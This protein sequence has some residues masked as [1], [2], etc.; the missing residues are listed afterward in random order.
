MTSW[1]RRCAFSYFGWFGFAAKYVA[2]LGVGAEYVVG[3][4]AN[5]VNL[6]GLGAG[7]QRPTEWIYRE[8]L[9]CA[10]KILKYAK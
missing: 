4:G 10:V 2:G 8:I 1:A 3:L 7:P 6:V 9:R 5:V